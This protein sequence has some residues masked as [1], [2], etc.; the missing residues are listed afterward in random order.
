M[1]IPPKQ[2]VHGTTVVVTNGAVG[3][4]V[5][6]EVMMIMMGDEL[7]ELDA[8]WGATGVLEGE[9]VKLI[10]G[11]VEEGVVAGTTVVTAVVTIVVFIL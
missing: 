9:L 6:A 3:T 11:P 10:N 1:V 4:G 7:A 2:V 5:V 8:D